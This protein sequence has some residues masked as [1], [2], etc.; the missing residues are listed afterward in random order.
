ME[1]KNYKKDFDY[2]YTLGAFPTIELLK[3]HKDDVID[4]YIH[5][6]FDNKEVKKM[7]LDLLG[8]EYKKN[9]KL[10]NK[11]S[12][13]ENCY[14]VGI[15]KKYSCILATNENHL[16]LDNPSNMGNLG[17]IIRS[18][19][20]FGI[21]NIA[22]IKPGVDIFDPKVVRASMGS[23]F[24]VNIEYY[25]CI[26]DYKV[27]NKDHTIYAFMLKAKNNLQTFKFKKGLSTLAFGNEAT[28][29]PDSY[30]DDNSIIIKH[31][32]DIDSLNL[33][34]AVSIALYEFNR[35]NY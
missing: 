24:S 19:L 34:N 29:L 1:I 23:I 32:H 7:I 16:L 6:S 22:I 11:L 18:S 9:D 10:I 27:K 33:T 5:S 15:F 28:G 20:G 25:S 35:Q 14:I 3:H 13:K 2:S 12:P 26:D 4:I 21:K 8:H 30:L 17:T 31:T